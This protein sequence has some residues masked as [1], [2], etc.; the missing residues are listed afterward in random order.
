[1]NFFGFWRCCTF[2]FKTNSN[3]LHKALS[4]VTRQE[5]QQ[6]SCLCT[7]A[8]FARN[9]HSKISGKEPVPM[10]ASILK[11]QYFDYFLILDFEATCEENKQ[12]HPQVLYQILIVPVVIAYLNLLDRTLRKF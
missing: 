12:I 5:V 8:L 3:K 6:S 2:V 7:S 4:S 10:A 9:K 1:M 11:P